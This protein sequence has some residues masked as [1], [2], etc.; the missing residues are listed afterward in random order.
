MALEL[1]GNIKGPKGDQGVKGDQGEQ[2]LPAATGLTD[3]EA[4][5]AHVSL[6][7]PTRDALLADFANLDALDSGIV[8]LSA[9]RFPGIAPFTG[10]V[11][12]APDMGPA[13]RAAIATVPRGSIVRLPEGTYCVRTSIAL[14]RG[15]TFWNHGVNFVVDAAVPLFTM[16]GG[17]GNTYAV[18]SVVESRTAL[19]SGDLQWVQ[20]VTVNATVTESWKRGDVVRM[21]ANDVIPGGRPGSGGAESRVGQFFDV[22][23]MS[24]GGGTTTIVLQ[25]RLLD[26][27]TTGIRIARLNTEDV[28]NIVGGTYDRSDAIIAAA[29][30]GEMFRADAAY[31]PSLR[32]LSIRRNIG[33]DV[34]FGGS[35]GWTVDN[36][37]SNWSLN[38][39][40]TSFGYGVIDNQGAFG[41]LKDSI[42]YGA[43]HAYSDDTVR[44]QSGNTNL[45]AY[46]RSY[47]HRVYGNTAVNCSSSAYDT[48]H[49]SQSIQFSDNTAIGGPAFAMGLRGR[50]HVVRGLTSLGSKSGVR[51]F[52]E[53]AGGESWGHDIDGVLVDGYSSFGLEIWVNPVSGVRESAARRSRVRN[54]RA[55]NPVALTGG[56]SVAVA[57]NALNASAVIEDFHADAPA[58]VGASHDLMTTA[59]S[60]IRGRGWV[61]DYVA[62]TAGTSLDVVDTDGNNLLE[63]DGLRVLSP[64]GLFGGRMSRIFN[65]TN[66]DRVRAQRVEMDEYP[67]TA[68]NA[69]VATG[70]FVEFHALS[71][72]ESSDF[73]TMTNTTA[74]DAAASWLARLSRTRRDLVVEANVTA[75]VTIPILPRGQRY[76]Q[77]LTIVQT[78]AA[79]IVRIVHGSAGLTLLSGAANAAL[80]QYGT[81]TLVWSPTSG[82]RW[83]QA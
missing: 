57:L 33:P 77:K 25:G 56:T 51:I 17:H 6:T 36:L 30:V 1:I 44:I 63:I 39:S 27:M 67:A 20:T 72:G 64:S 48:H 43:R 26:P 45:A 21:V 65:T 10:S 75:D 11:A 73:D 18:A 12:S 66:T 62:N 31:R 53:D 83:R 2:G 40:T 79:G 54:F 82:G 15:V 61:A 41:T 24:S 50:K 29:T 14:T 19:E 49:C 74:V 8:V 32:D 13:I 69:S 71:T 37:K 68:V 38:D 35:Y 46:G 55:V 3:G 81:I 16:T 78:G 4:L 52:T 7:G 5:A 28:F 59:N 76:G 9:D 70:S 42:I 23:S 47:A 22:L 60:D 58:V 34:V 80:N